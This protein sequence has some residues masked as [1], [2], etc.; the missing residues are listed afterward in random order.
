MKTGLNRV[1]LNQGITVFV[2][3]FIFKYYFV[4]YQIIFTQYFLLTSKLFKGLPVVPIVL[5]KHLDRGITRVFTQLY[6]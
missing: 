3:V 5:L 1:G 4:R 6:D 2:H